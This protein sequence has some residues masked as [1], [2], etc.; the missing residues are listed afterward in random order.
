VKYELKVYFKHSG[1]G[2][3]TSQL[4]SKNVKIKTYKTIILSVVLHGRVTLSLTLREEHRLR[5][6]KNRVVRMIFG[7]KRI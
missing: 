7:P 4:L 5:V 6:F 2:V 3:Q 1:C